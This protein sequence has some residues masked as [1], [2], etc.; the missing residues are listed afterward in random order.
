MEPQH[1][2]VLSRDVGIVSA[3]EEGSSSGDTSSGGESLQHQHDDVVNEEVSGLAMLGDTA[4]FGAKESSGWYSA[5][6]KDCGP[7]TVPKQRRPRSLSFSVVKNTSWRANQHRESAPAVP[8]AGSGGHRTFN[9]H[10]LAQNATSL[11]AD[12]IHK[13][14]IMPLP[15]AG[16]NTNSLLPKG[17]G[18]AAGN[19]TRPI[20]LS[21]GICTRS[22]QLSP[23]VTLAGGGYGFAQQ[24]VEQP[25]SVKKNA[26]NAL[27][28]R[29]TRN[30]KEKERSIRIA[31]KIDELQYLLARGGVTL[32]KGTKT[33]ILSEAARYIREMQ[34]PSPCFLYGCLHFLSGQRHPCPARKLVGIL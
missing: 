9:Y 13:T 19:S 7:H 3:E 25:R 10:N 20:S 18:V 24:Q 32:P 16:H 12:R 1:V 14:P 28:W 6:K 31:R 27:V 29:K 33:S 21:A 17:A 4:G 8:G 15:P 11:Y 5:S 26:V 34:A 30:A 23:N 22:D 2:V